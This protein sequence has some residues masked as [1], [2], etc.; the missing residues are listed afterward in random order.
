MSDHEKKWDLFEDAI[1]LLGEGRWSEAE[2]VFEKLIE[3]EPDRYINWLMIGRCQL[4][5][6]K[7]A[8][9]EKSSRKALAMHEAADT[10]N[11]LGCVLK[12]KESFP[13]AET[14]FRNSLSFNPRDA[15]SWS[16]LGTV[17]FALNKDK[18]SEES[19]KMSIDLKP[20]FFEGWLVMGMLNLRQGNAHEAE[21]HFR[22]LV[23]LVPKMP[24]AH[25]FLALSLSVQGKHAE[26]SAERAKA[27]SLRS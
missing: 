2:A 25:D 22:K 5:Q 4:S 26:A 21:N 12:A 15:T 16:G 9:A 7:L 23:E 13:E 8:E 11:L 1:R 27:A 18:E 10:W 6:R 20:D 24:D 3:L 17:L 14:A 19:A